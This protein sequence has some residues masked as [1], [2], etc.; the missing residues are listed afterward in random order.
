MELENEVNKQSK[1][2][3]DWSQRPCGVFSIT[4]EQSTLEPSYWKSFSSD[5]IPYFSKF[6]FPKE[7]EHLA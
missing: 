3:K 7:R 5:L 6:N 2:G 4:N 1:C